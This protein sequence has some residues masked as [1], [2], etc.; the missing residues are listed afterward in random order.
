MVRRCEWIGAFLPPNTHTHTLLFKQS[1]RS[2]ALQYDPTGCIEAL[3]GGKCVAPCV[4]ALSL[5]P[6]LRFLVGFGGA[7]RLTSPLTHRCCCVRAPFS[8]RTRGGRCSRVRA[9]LDCRGGLAGNDKPLLAPT[10][11]CV[12]VCVCER[13]GQSE[14]WQGV[15][16][17]VRVCVCGS[18]RACISPDSVECRHPTVSLLDQTH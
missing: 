10:C 12:C 4:C 6:L 8:P 16:R 13:L 9:A 17:H 18:V 1:H 5:R 11:G 3:T 15:S 7:F 2:L 14:N